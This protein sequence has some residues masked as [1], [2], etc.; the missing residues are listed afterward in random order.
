MTKPENRSSA[1]DCAQEFETTGDLLVHKV[2]KNAGRET[3]VFGGMRALM[4]KIQ[5]VNILDGG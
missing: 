4:P 1:G 5:Q 3:F 2:H